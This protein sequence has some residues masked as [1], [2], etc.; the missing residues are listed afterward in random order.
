MVTDLTK[1]LK[2]NFLWVLFILFA[3]MAVALKKDTSI[4][5]SYGPYGIGK[6][7]FWLLFFSFLAFTIYA[8]SKESFFKSLK[9][10]SE[11]YWGWQIGLDLYIGLLFPL[12]I[13][14]LHG[15]SFIFLCWLIPIII[16]A[17][18]FTLLYFALNYDSLVAQFI[19]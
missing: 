14:Y 2:K 4:F 16:N 18:L 12:L 3:I 15:G 8:N 7:I 5:V 17:N 9:R 10:F 1:S 13:I 11:L 6:Y 19:S